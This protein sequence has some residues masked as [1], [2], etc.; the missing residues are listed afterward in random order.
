[1]KT[2]CAEELE[3]IKLAIGADA[4]GKGRFDEALELFGQVALAEDFVDF[5]TIPAYECLP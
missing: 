3:T 1:V 2:V 4:F 5:L